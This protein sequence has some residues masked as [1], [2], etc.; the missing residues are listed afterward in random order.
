MHSKNI[1]L[2]LLTAA[3]ASPASAK[4]IEAP[5]ADV[6]VYPDRAV[7]TRSTSFELPAG[8][9]EVTLTNLSEHLLDESVQ[10]SAKSSG[11]LS[12]LNVRTT[13]RHGRPDEI[14]RLQPLLQKQ[15]EVQQQIDD[16]TLQLTLLQQQID[17]LKKV[18]N[19]VTG[20]RTEGP[21][22]T[23]TEWNELRVFFQD[24][25]SDLLPRIH[26]GNKEREALE[27]ELEAIKREIA[28]TRDAERTRTKQAV[29]RVETDEDL[30]DA[31]LSLSYVV[32]NAGWSPAYNLRVASSDKSVKLDYQANIRQ[33]TGEDWNG[34]N[35]TLSTARPA[36][37]GNAPELGRWTVDVRRPRPAPRPEAARAP[38][39][40][41]S[42]AFVDADAMDHQLAEA[43][44][45]TGLTAVNLR[46]PAKTTI[47]AD[48]QPHRVG[49]SSTPLSGE[50]YYA[51][52]PKLSSHA[53]LQSRVVHTGSA[54]I[55]P[56]R[57]SIFLDGNLV[58]HSNLSRV[59]PDET[60]DLPLGV[61]EAIV[62]ER[63][64]LR[65]FTDQRGIL[66]KT[67]RTRFEFQTTVT[68]RRSTPEKVVIK[69]HVPVSQDDRIK[70]DLVQLSGGKS[71][72]DTPGLYTWEKTVSAGGKVEIPLTFTVEHPEDLDV[73]GL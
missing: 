13:T 26:Q 19:N 44:V 58:G 1:L 10:V 63:K 2:F 55:L 5:I 38:L 15:E 61:D 46:I 42:E 23:P 47:P 48:N 53:Y 31:V 28:Q 30:T 49:I 22:P 24:S 43:R 33:R 3:A 41:D 40:A 34:V 52:V 70:V 29:V 12:I 16:V 59:E 71:D 60:F 65:R 9:T 21:L 67:T 39:R 69:D 17:F 7:V 18:E 37:G 20:K 6:T 50:F 73:S 45:E 8:V 54:P 35:V 14:E 27:K 64:L 68:N 62:V 57:A 11:N 72:E 25:L 56:G 51:V 36:L 4:S 32:M 66:S